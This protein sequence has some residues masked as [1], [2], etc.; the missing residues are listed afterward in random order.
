VTD[1]LQAH[2]DFWQRKECR[3]PL[4]SFRIG[5]TFVAR[6]F[7]AARHLLV[8]R[9]R[10]TPDMIVVDDFLAD[11]ERMWTVAQDIG[12]SGIWRSPPDDSL[13]ASPSCGAPPTWWAP[14]SA[15]PR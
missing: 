14:S 12:Q 13:S 1:R 4:V 11:Y 5:D 15:R 3:K 2:N 10:I 9:M 8:D 6:H 7:A